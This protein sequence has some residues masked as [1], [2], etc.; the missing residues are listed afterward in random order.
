M[1]IRLFSFILVGIGLALSADTYA[2]IEGGND[3]L[4]DIIAPDLER[5][6]IK[7]ARVDTENWEVGAFVGVMAIEDFGTGAVYGARVDLSLIH[8]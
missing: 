2:Q 7:E 3:P 6:E 5:R 4:G 8:I 1:A